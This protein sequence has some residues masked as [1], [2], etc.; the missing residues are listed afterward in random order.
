MTLPREVIEA[1][2]NGQV[3][4]LTAENGDVYYFKVPG[5][6]DMN[7]YLATAARGKV[8]TAV[9]SLV[10]DLALYPDTAELKSRFAAKPGLMVALNNALQ[11]AVGIN[12]EFDVKKL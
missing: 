6:Q 4:E 9:S 10:A 8:A 7:R 2:E 12:E 11:N 5:K 3:L 1:K